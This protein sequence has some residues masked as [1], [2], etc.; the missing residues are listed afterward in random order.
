MA[1]WIEVSS[2]PVL[3]DGVLGGTSPD[4][5]STTKAPGHVLAVAGSSPSVHQKIF[6]TRCLAGPIGKSVSAFARRE[7]LIPFFS[8]NWSTGLY[9]VGINGTSRGLQGLRVC[10]TSC[11]GGL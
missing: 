10:E 6:R 1:G 5:P 7:L 2:S 3:G 8:P 11:F 9:A 4:E